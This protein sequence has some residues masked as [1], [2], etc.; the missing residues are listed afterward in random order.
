[1]GNPREL[2]VFVR[3]SAAVLAARS[4]GH[5]DIQEPCPEG[6]NEILSGQREQYM[7]KEILRRTVRGV[8]V[9]VFC[10]ADRADNLQKLLQ[11]SKSGFSGGANGAESKAATRVW[12]VLLVLV[13]LV[14][15]IYL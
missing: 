13:Y 2:P 7:A 9:V 3:H 14:L 15:P 1:M 12:P 5:S 6:V 8:D 11:G 4:Q 10:T